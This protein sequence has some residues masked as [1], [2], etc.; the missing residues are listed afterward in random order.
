M[1]ESC[2][3][4]AGTFSTNDTQC[5]M[6]SL[7]P[8]DAEELDPTVQTPKVIAKRLGLIEKQARDEK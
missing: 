6:S 4:T 7:Q 8:L 3:Q 1:S 2:P 5:C